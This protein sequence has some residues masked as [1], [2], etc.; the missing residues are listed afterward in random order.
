M[1]A[2]LDHGAKPNRLLSTPGT[3]LQSAL[4]GAAESGNCEVVGL[5]LQTGVDVNAL[6]HRGT[7]LSVAVSK[8]HDAVVHL[9]LNRT[10]GQVLAAIRHLRSRGRRRHITKLLRLVSQFRR[11]RQEGRS[12]HHKELVSA[13]MHT[14]RK[15]IINQHSTMV[16][17]ASGSA[18][19]FRRLSASFLHYRDT[20]D[21]G[22]HTMRNL[23][24]GHFPK[25]IAETIP[26]LCLARAMVET[27]KDLYYGNYLEDFI[28]DLPRWQMIFSS[29]DQ[30]QDLETYRE[31]IWSM[32][33]VRVDSVEAPDFDETVERFHDLASALA[34]KADLI[35]GASS[36]NTSEMSKQDCGG[37]QRQ[38]ASGI[39][40]E[41]A[42]PSSDD[43][44]PFVTQDD[45]VLIE[46]HLLTPKSWST[47][48]RTLAEEIRRDPTIVEPLAT[49]L[50]AGAVFAIIIV[51]L[52]GE[53][54][55]CAFAV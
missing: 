25:S 32:W 34:S 15:H 12:S 4:I 5:L 10:G 6:D 33:N 46:D 52:Q 42:K 23:C 18:T 11:D 1:Q 7:A 54:R 17:S 50:I 24:G 39:W 43:A 35:Y 26:F 8:N 16:S 21:A 13:N 45:T 55:R 51:Y 3:E 19:E 28:A 38:T 27:L 48:G 9:L 22:I 40:V 14:L 31:A 47:P 2:L 37:E 49:F 30:Q 44:S 36:P 29:N 53:G 41:G 20:W